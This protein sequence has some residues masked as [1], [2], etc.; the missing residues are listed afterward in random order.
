MQKSYW[1]F[2]GDEITFSE[3]EMIVGTYIDTNT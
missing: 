1:Y 2:L 3:E